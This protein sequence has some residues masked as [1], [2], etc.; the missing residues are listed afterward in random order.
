MSQRVGATTKG[1]IKNNTTGEVRE[2]QFNPENFSYSRGV[3]YANLDAPGMEYPDTQFVKGNARE[4]QVT[5][6]FFDKPFTN[7]FKTYT[8]FFGGLMTQETNRADFKKPTDCTFVFGSWVRKCVV[9]D[10]NI[11]VQE[12]DGNLNP[13][14]FTCT[15]SLRQV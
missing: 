6:F 1:L 5:L 4:F 13:V 9:T 3:T 7:K 10:L 2:F 11:S 15:L 14:I 12:Y 8:W